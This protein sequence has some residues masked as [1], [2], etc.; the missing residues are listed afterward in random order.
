MRAQM[1][2]EKKSNLEKTRQM[3]A[4]NVARKD[5]AR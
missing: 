5:M 3:R 4:Q 1:W 2:R